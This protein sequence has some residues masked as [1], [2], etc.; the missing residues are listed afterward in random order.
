M[1]HYFVRYSFVGDHFQYLASMG[2]LALVGG[3][4]ARLLVRLGLWGRW[5]GNGICLVLLAA[6]AT[7]TWR[8][9]GMYESDERLYR[10]TLAL[11]PTCWLA[12]NNLGKMLIDRGELDEAVS[13]YQEA[14]KAAPRVAEPHNNMGKALLKSGKT[15]DAI[16]EFRRAIEIDPTYAVA[17]NNLGLLLADL[18]QSGA[19]VQEFQKAVDA[20]PEYADAH[21]NLGLMLMGAGSLARPSSITAGRWQSA[22][23]SRSP[24]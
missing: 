23:A 12:H 19:A 13:H 2:I 9:N 1:N 15:E 7:L 16:A 11:N 4:L 3:G 20:Y 21:M 6:L 17:H 10:T 24:A 22:P 5:S 14:I 8:Q 18:K